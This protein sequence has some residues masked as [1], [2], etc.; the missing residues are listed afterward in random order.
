MPVAEPA[1]VVE[2]APVPEPSARLIGVPHVEPPV[3]V[4]EPVVEPAGASP[5]L[6][7]EAIEAT[8]SLNVNGSPNGHSVEWTPSPEPEVSPAPSAPFEAPVVA[9]PAE[10]VAATPSPVR[11]EPPAPIQVPEPIEV[12]PEPAVAAPAPTPP[13]W[14]KPQAQPNGGRPYF[15]A[16]ATKSPAPA[17]SNAAVAAPAPQPAAKPALEVDDRPEL[18]SLS[19]PKDGLSRQWLEFLSQLGAT[20]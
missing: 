5:V 6:Q 1:V 20:K 10:V 13:V 4:D 15:F 3:P 11:I 9:A 7:L 19:F 17:E 16:Q 8:A 14:A 2:A 12:A 18:E